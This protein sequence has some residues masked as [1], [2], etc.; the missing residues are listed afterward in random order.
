MYSLCGTGRTSR[1]SDAS[2]VGSLDMDKIR[3]V[4]GTKEKVEE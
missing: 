4:R 2:S 1:M 3:A